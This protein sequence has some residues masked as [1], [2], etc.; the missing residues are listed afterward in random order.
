MKAFLN[1]EMLEFEEKSPSSV[2]S[3]LMLVIFLADELGKDMYY[4]FV[5]VV[6]VC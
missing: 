2:G 3:D 5:D 4:L 1:A 6:V